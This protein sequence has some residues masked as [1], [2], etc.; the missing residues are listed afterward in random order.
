M[1]APIISDLQRTILDQVAA[2]E[3]V[4]ITALRQQVQ[5]HLPAVNAHGVRNAVGAL[6]NAGMLVFGG[7]RDGKCYSLGAVMPLSDLAR[8]HSALPVW[9][10]IVHTLKTAAREVSSIELRSAY[11]HLKVNKLYCVLNTLV[12]TG[13]IARDGTHGEYRYRFVS[14]VP[15]I[16][17]AQSRTLRA[18]RFAVSL[19]RS[20][21][22][23]DLFIAPQPHWPAYSGQPLGAAAIGIV[24]TQTLRKA[25]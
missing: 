18:A 22:P 3:P 14:D 13:R 10:Q 9:K 24:C 5:A 12:D 6:I 4:D 21:A 23:I 11:P 15:T 8:G 19:P 1:N 7:G 20:T 2:M 17:R 25:A 16:N